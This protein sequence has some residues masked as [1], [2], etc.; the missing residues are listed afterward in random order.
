MVKLVLELGFVS[1]PL[2]QGTMLTINPPS[3]S[4]NQQ[5]SPESDSVE[6]LWKVLV[7]MRKDS[8]K[9]ERGVR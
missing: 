5:D 2:S 1:A 4:R 6:N 7:K 9:Q 3:C 8:E